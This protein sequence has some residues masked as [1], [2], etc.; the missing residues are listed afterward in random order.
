MPCWIECKADFERHI[1]RFDY[2]VWLTFCGLWLDKSVH[3]LHGTMC[4]GA[5][6]VLLYIYMIQ[7]P[8]APAS[9]LLNYVP[10]SIMT[11]ISKYW[12]RFNRPCL[13][14]TTLSPLDI[15]G[16]HKTIASLPKPTNEQRL[17]AREEPLAVGG[18]V[19]KLN[20]EPCFGLFLFVPLC[21]ENCPPYRDLWQ[22]SSQPLCLKTQHPQ[23]MENI[24]PI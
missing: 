8:H 13:T 20:V 12:R 7:R 17:T 19:F 1:V 24:S 5:F 16:R 4:A 9:T 15:S 21:Q 14:S 23:N 6:I 11:S 3:L 10:I 2:W 18:P 22:R